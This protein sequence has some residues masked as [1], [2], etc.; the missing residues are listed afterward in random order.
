VALFLQPVSEHSSAK[1]LAEAVDFAYPLGDAIIIGATLGVFA[2]MGWR[3]G[4]MWL[5][6]GLGLLS[7]GLADAINSVQSLR[8]S[9]I[10]GS[11]YD[12]AWAGGAVLVAYAAW[13]PHPGRVEPRQVFGL[14]AVALPLAAQVL[15]GGI[16]IYGYFHEIPKSERILTLFV[17]IIAMVQIVVTRPRRPSADRA[18]PE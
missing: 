17:L 6:L 1:A 4:R 14:R 7:I 16:Q 12:A 9:D 3:P 13:Q 2:L 11:Y 18:G 15:A 10:Q 5:F 8:D